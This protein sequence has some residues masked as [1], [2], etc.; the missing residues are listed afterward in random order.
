MSG[1]NRVEQYLIDL[2]IGYEEVKE[3][4]WLVKDPS[5]GLAAVVVAYDEPVVLVSCK[6]MKLPSAKREEFMEKLL[7]LNGSDLI[8]G[9]YALQGDDV[10]LVDTLQYDSMDKEEFEASLDAVGLALS[11][12]YPVLSAYRA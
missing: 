7:R 12:H 11:Q 4:T 1:L 6:V 3:G 2:N 8:H 9:A 10:I 5:R